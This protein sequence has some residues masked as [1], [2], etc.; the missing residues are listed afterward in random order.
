MPLCSGLGEG[1]RCCFSN[2][3]L[4]LKDSLLLE[5][6]VRDGLAGGHYQEVITGDPGSQGHPT[7]CPERGGQSVT[8][9]SSANCTKQWT[10][11]GAPHP[12][13]PLMPGCLSW[14]DIP[15]PARSVDPFFGCGS[16]PLTSSAFLYRCN[17]N[18]HAVWNLGARGMS[19]PAFA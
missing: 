6:H 3:D 13:R 19:E 14:C 15:C 16:Y 17:A 5:L 11:T 18:G 10:P 9:E 4:H 8:W 7:M 2:P 1:R 12:G